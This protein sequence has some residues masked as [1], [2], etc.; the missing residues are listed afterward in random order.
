MRYLSKLVILSLSKSYKW[1]SIKI[2]CIS[3]SNEF[4][5]KL[6]QS[7]VERRVKTENY[8]SIFTENYLSIF[9]FVGVLNTGIF[10]SF[11]K[12]SFWKQTGYFQQ[13]NFLFFGV[14]FLGAHT[15][16]EVWNSLCIRPC[17]SGIDCW[18]IV[19]C[20]MNTTHDPLLR[21]ITKN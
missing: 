1:G 20:T 2:Y 18:R 9:A 19:P 21:A 17:Q 13:F 6:F 16:Q 15:G 5:A 11:I 4:G 10:M 14:I 8:L 3:L 12:L 7:L